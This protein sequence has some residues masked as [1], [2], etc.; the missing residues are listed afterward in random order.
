MRPEVQAVYQAG[1][2]WWIQ[3]RRQLFD[4][5]IAAW[6]D[7]PAESRILELGP[8]YGVMLDMLQAHGQV[9]VV[10]RDPASVQVCR[11]RGARPA[12]C[13]AAEHL[14]LA[15]GSF[16]L[17]CAFDIFE[18]LDADQAAMAEV[19]RVLRPGGSLLCTV[20]ALGLLWGR[21]DI[22][23]E[24]RRRYRR[25]ELRAQLEAAGFEVLRLSYFNSWLFPPILAFRLLSRP[26]ARRARGSDMDLR[27]PRLV[28]RGL[29]GVLRSES[30]LLRRFDLPLGVSLIA[31][32]RR[33]V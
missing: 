11:E 17:C 27:L 30:G 28:E 21:Q 18:H 19:A 12:L 31:H 26:F 13:A 14:P 15:D 2:H 25:A 1:D 4:R 22:Y 29:A 32:A 9:A 16:D 6:I 8:G 3:G 23:A 20:P 24:H 7:L 10:D 5:L 33:T